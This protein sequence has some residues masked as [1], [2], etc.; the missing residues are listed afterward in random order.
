MLQ[1]M[2]FD[3]NALSN[4]YV[5]HLVSVAKGSLFSKLNRESLVETIGH[6]SS[7]GVEVLVRPCLLNIEERLSNPRAKALEV[8]GGVSRSNRLGYRLRLGVTSSDG[9]PTFALD[10]LLAVEKKDDRRG[11]DDKVED[12]EI[13]ASATPS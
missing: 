3:E 9:L 10:L 7:D 1:R 2:C 5:R 6:E 4:R 13:T 12:R 8:E 11:D